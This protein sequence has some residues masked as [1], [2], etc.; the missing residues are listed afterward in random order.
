MEEYVIQVLTRDNRLLGTVQGR[1][2]EILLQG[3]EKM[4]SKREEIVEHE[5]R[6]EVPL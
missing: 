3:V 1:N 6:E 5:K 2:P 4:I